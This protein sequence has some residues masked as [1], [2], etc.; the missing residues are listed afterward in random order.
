M[1][2]ELLKAAEQ[3]L[4]YDPSTGHLM[5]RATGKRAGTKPTKTRLYR[6]VQIAGCEVL[7][8]VLIWALHNGAWPEHEVDHINRVRTDNRL[9]NLRN[10][11]RSENQANTALYASNTSGFRGVFYSKRNGRWAAAIRVGGRSQWLGYHDTPEQAY[12][13][14]KAACAQAG[15]RL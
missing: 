10:A 15:R 6:R 13:A 5:W 14:Y 7:E 12:E 4:K 9:Q 3:R 1:R 2:T 11:T 8:H